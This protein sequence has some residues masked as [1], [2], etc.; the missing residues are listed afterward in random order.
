MR[1]KNT[2]SEPAL[3]VSG[4]PQGSV[5]GPLLFLIFISDLGMDLD[6]SLVKI[7]KYVDDTKVLGVIDDDDQVE[8]FQANLNLVFDWAGKKQYEMEF[9]EVLTS[10]VWIQ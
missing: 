9:T 3:L 5:L 2:L 7:L 8:S 1:V 6:D 10:K 4:V